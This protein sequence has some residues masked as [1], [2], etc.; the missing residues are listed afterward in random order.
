MARLARI[1]IPGRP[2]LVFQPTRMALFRDPHDEQAYRDLLEANAARYGLTITA[3]ATAGEAVRLLATPAARDSL[4]R[5][6]G[7]TRRLFAR[8]RNLGLAALWRG[9][10]L[11]CVVAPERLPAAL[12]YIEDGAADTVEAAIRTGR[13]FGDADFIASLEYETGRRLAAGKRGRKP[14]W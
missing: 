3:L 8:R 10:F 9:R 11:S 2:H 1:V 13:P 7:E 12:A 4:A 14:K 5:A 6:I